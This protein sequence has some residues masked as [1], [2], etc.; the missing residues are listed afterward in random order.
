MIAVSLTCAASALAGCVGSPPVLGVSALEGLRLIEKQLGLNL[1]VTG[2]MSITGLEEYIEPPPGHTYGTVT[3]W[4]YYFYDSQ[5]STVRL[6]A[7]NS[8]GVLLEDHTR[9]AYGV[10]GS[11]APALTS[12]PID[13]Q[14]VAQLVS[15]SQGSP[16]PGARILYSLETLAG[17][18]IWSVRYTPPSA[19]TPT[20]LAF[21]GNTGASLSVSGVPH[22]QGISM[23]VA[24]QVAENAIVVA[25]PDAYLIRAS[26]FESKPVDAVEA[27]LFL[28][29]YNYNKG[30]VPTPDL[31]PM[32][33][34]TTWWALLYYSPSQH[35]VWPVF[36][37][38]NL[39]PMIGDPL[40]APVSP[41]IQGAPE[42][43]VDP[44]D[45]IHK[46]VDKSWASYQLR[47]RR[48]WG[49]EI[50]HLEGNWRAVF[51]ATTG[52]TV[53]CTNCSP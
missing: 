14:Q 12:L 36:V 30:Y 19:T 7:L 3:S 24:K 41:P 51:D 32:D 53:T 28:P 29:P 23:S 40:A 5:S 11:V 21:N 1:Q 33:G 38:A 43:L 9:S 37:Y 25:A 48:G 17:Y 18:P 31:V 6:V 15:G 22:L 10:F 13:S 49:W 2:L 35:Q 4:T 20:L 47:Q 44:L 52:E 8:R 26:S 46:P 34:L 45:F 16:G 27:I 42:E 50:N 39:I